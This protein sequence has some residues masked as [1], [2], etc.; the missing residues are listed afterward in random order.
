[1]NIRRAFEV[2]EIGADATQDE[3]RQAYKDLVAVWHPDRFS[4]N[5]RLRNKA[6]EKLKEANLAFETVKHF[7][8]TRQRETAGKTAAH[9]TSDNS[10]EQSTSSGTKTELA[11]ELGTSAVLT[12]WSF[13]SRKINRMLSDDVKGKKG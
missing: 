12:L 1:M 2:L 3:A 4:H 11:A 9:E 5:P 8:S 13:L 6:E 10:H 7:F